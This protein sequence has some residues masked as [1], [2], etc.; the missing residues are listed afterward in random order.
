[1]NEE[2]FTEELLDKIKVMLSC[3]K[4]FTSIDDVEQ[5]VIESMKDIKR[6]NDI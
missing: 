2:E 3:I 5:E 1:M 4:E 6:V